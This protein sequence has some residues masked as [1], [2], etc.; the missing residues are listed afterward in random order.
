MDVV[1]DVDSALAA[2]LDNEFP[3]ETGEK[4]LRIYGAMQGLFIQQDALLDLIKAIHPAK[5]ICL[6][7]VLKDIREARNASVGHPTQLKRKGALSA[8][9]IVQ[10]SMRKDGFSLLS[11][12]EKDGKMFQYIAVS[13]VD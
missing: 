13:R 1:D 12:P 8:H 11:Y 5:G 3:E 4:Y 7:D 10:H 9:G 6:N 2:Y